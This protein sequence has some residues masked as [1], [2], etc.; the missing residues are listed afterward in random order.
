M[1][2]IT[3]GDPTARRE[4]GR[5][6]ANPLSELLGRFCIAQVYARKLKAA[7]HEMDMGIIE[8]GQHELAFGINRAG[9]GAAE[10]FDFIIRT[11]GDYAPAENCDRFRSWLRRSQSTNAGIEEPGRIRA[12]R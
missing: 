10:L 8:T 6:I 7:G 9:V 3:A 12:L 11:N 1:V 4:R 2:P 5:K